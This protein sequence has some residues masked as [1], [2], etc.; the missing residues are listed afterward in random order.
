MS[1][2]SPSFDP[3]QAVLREYR[4]LAT[5]YDTRWSSYVSS[6]VRETVCRLELRP[7]ERVLEV[8]CGTGALLR[9]LR[10][11]H[12]DVRLTGVDPCAEMLRQARTKLDPSV[13]LR[14]AWAE[15]LP[16]A[17]ERFDVVVFCN[18]FHY[19]HEPRRALGQAARV[20]KPGG[21]LVVTDWCDDYLAC[22]LCDLFLRLFSPAHHKTYGSG[23]C[24][25]LLG[26]TGFAA[27]QVERYKISWLWGL[28][29]ATARKPASF[30]SAPESRAPQC[31][32]L[33]SW[34]PAGAAG[35]NFARTG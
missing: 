32:L 25:A 19:F 33:T 1:L 21:R 7:G 8:G 18:V 22:K 2:L 30:A 27:V 28:M 15:W 17:D 23:E 9:A 35:V 20:L 24:A 4:R 12:P 26:E 3:R 14:E 10:A 34:I 16:F 11:A 29:A 6:T 13:E 5:E 31:R